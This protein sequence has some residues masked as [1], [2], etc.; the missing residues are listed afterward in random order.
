M[1]FQAI[2]T[3]IE[4]TLNSQAA[5]RYD[6][7]GYQRQSKGAS[8][9]EKLVTVYYK[10]GSFPK[11]AAG[12]YGSP[13]KHD[14][15]FEIEF[16]VSAESEVDLSVLESASSTP[17]QRSA[18]LLALQNGA[19]LADDQIDQL[20]S[21]VWNVIMDAENAF[22]GLTDYSVQDRW[23]EDIEKDNPMPR[24]EYIILTGRSRLT[25]SVS[26]IPGGETGTAGTD[27]DTT[28]NIQDDPND[29]AGASG[30]LGG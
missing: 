22:F 8:T 2:K 20:F 9:F 25:C 19:K 11:S 1:E 29:N 10:S 3:A 23:I 6:V 12:I 26:E 13:V 4:T 27:F 7:V 21:D 14:M 28:V 5:G 24:G 18:A 15:S 30:N 16:T 17:A